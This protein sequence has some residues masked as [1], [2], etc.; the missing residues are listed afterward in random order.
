MLSFY[1]YFF[2]NIAGPVKRAVPLNPSLF[3][4]TLKDLSECG[5]TCVPWDISR[6]ILRSCPAL[7]FCFAVVRLLL[8]H[9]RL[10][11][12]DFECSHEQGNIKVFDIV[13]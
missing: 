9:D 4:Q 5:M 6:I 11:W 2:N 8:T 7:C 10:F 1:K 12:G 13:L 3:R